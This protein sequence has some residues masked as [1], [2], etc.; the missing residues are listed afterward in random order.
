[1]SDPAA[2]LAVIIRA[3]RSGDRSA[4][5]DALTRLTGQHDIRVF[6]GDAL[7]AR[8]NPTTETPAGRP[9]QADPRR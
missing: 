8:A 4:E 5:A 6:F 2:L 1:M 7:V 3:R 9:R